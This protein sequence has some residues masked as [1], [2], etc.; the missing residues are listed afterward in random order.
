[1]YSCSVFQYFYAVGAINIINFLIKF[2]ITDRMGKEHS[3]QCRQALS[4][5]IKPDLTQNVSAGSKIEGFNFG[6]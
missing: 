3:Q 5:D 6:D 4:L 2:R 1:M